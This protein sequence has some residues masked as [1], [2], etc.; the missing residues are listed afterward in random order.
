MTEQSLAFDVS[1]F[2]DWRI[3]EAVGEWADR[4]INSLDAV[5]DLIKT[6]VEGLVDFTERLLTG[7]PDVAVIA[8]LVLLAFLASGWRLATFAAVAFSLIASFGFFEPTMESLALV[9]VATVIAVAAGVPLGIWAARSQRVSTAIRPVLDFMQTMPSFV[10]LLVAVSMFS[11]GSAPGVMSAVIFSMPPAVRLTELGIRQVDSEVVE[12]AHAFGATPREILTGVQ[13]PLA[14]PTIMA[15]INQV[16]ML[17]L[18]MVV[19]AGL[20]G[21]GGIGESVVQGVTRLQ[22]GLGLVA[23]LAVVILAVYLDRTT[24]ALGDRVGPNAHRPRRKTR[25][26]AAL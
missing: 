2:P 10:Y 15:G 1:V 12:A 11:I 13:L 18:S 14:M 23:G 7:P 3:T 19:I 16:I 17:S 25:Q 8:V 20:A 21:A 22:L 5:L 4:V 26:S 6:V 24:G 9:L